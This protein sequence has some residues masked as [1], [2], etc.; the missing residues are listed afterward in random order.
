MTPPPPAAPLFMGMFANTGQAIQAAAAVIGAIL[1]AIA[2]WRATAE[3]AR[4]GLLVRLGLVAALA[5]G[6]LAWWALGSTWPWLPPLLCLLGVALSIWLGRQLGPPVAATVIES[7]LRV[8]EVRLEISD[9]PHV[10]YKRKL[11]IVV[12]NQSDDEILLGPGTTWKA[13]QLRVRA[14]PQQVWEVEPAD[15]W[16]A[17]SWTHK[18][19]ARVQLTPGQAART[20]IGVHPGATESEVA[21]LRGHLGV[22]VIPLEVL[23]G[24]RERLTL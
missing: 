21:A 20:W 22:L 3:P 24:D 13:G 18:E 1:A 17:D 7:R 23:G 4:R 19:E 15:G 14:I 9:L 5:A 16:H 8:L 11:R 12:A 2:F 10:E 6:G